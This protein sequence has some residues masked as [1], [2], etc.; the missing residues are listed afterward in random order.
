[1]SRCTSSTAPVTPACTPTCCPAWTRARSAADRNFVYA[2]EAWQAELPDAAA[3]RAQYELGEV[4]ED[5]E[6]TDGGEFR[7]PHGMTRPDLR[8]S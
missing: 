3:A 8:A 4:V 1:M 5:V 7:T 6:V 2:Y